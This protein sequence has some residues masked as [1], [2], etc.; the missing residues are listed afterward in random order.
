M[1]LE[2]IKASIISIRYRNPERTWL[3]ATMK[4]SGKKDS[5]LA[6]GNIPYSE[7]DEPLQLYGE[8]K[9]DKRYGRQFQVTT[10]YRILPTSVS[11][12]RNYLAASED[13]KGVGTVR[14]NKLAEHFGQKLFEVLDS[15]DTKRLAECPSVSLELAQTIVS[16]WKQDSSI[17]QLSIYLSKYGVSPRWAG[18]I[19]KQWDA[20]T[21]VE[22][23]Q[24]NPYLLTAIDGI[25]FNTADDIAIA[26]GK[27][28]DS[29]E[30]IAAACVHTVSEAVQDGNVF[31]HEFQLIDAI[32]K[33][34]VPRGKNEAKVREQ[35]L[36]AVTNAIESGELKAEVINDGCSTL[37]LLYLPHLYKA[38]KELAES[39]VELN[40]FKHETPIKLEEYLKIVQEKQHVQ[41]SGKQVEAIRGAFSNHILVITGGPGTGKTTCT[42]AICELAEHLHLS[43]TLAAP[44]GRAAKRLSEVTERTATT[45]HRLLKWRDDGP[46]HTRGN[47]IETDV[48]IVDESSM[49]DLDLAAKLFSALPAES[50]VILIGDVDQLPAVGAGCTLR[51]IISSNTV[52]IVTLDSVFRQA[53]QSLIIR[54]AHLI[55]KGEMPRFPETKGVK[56]NSYVMWIP[57][58]S[59]PKEGG[60]D[61]AEWLKDK[62]ARLVSINIPEK[63]SGDKVIDP[64]KDIQVL[65]PMKKQ[66]LGTHELNKVLQQALNPNG[67]EF[68]AGGK[69]FRHGDRVMQTRNN[70]DDGMEVYNGDI[71]FIKSHSSEDKCVEVDFY[72]RKVMYDYDNLED[73]QLAYAQTIHKSQGSEYPIVVVVMAYQHWPMLERNLIYTAN[74]RAKELCLFMAS[75]G[76]I[77]RAVKN[78]PVKERNTYL[79]QR[80]KEYT[81]KEAEIA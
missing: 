70:Y 26:M 29:P 5:F 19:L 1:E 64:I 47:P 53:E 3:V 34:I 24:K 72:G 63:F 14:A 2:S 40:E 60:K 17:R 69:V 41:F 56:E 75:K 36:Q 28:K 50:S 77:E 10:A 25:G 61:D 13:I 79:A 9:E 20:G 76:A 22:N 81:L 32:V 23:I 46:T 11:G 52:P 62:L 31:L 16:G 15:G 57:P 21:A 12:L 66:S 18:R 54:N 67:Q 48:L 38:E 27:K 4:Y 37:R 58:N 30:R 80:L 33:L 39:I 73:L 42:K 43:I 8:W 6:T 51:D 59:N 7:D 74:T 45:I 78:N 49:L 68:V 55:R 65:V 35:A 71:G 44:T